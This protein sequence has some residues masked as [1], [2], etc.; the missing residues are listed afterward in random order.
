MRLFPLPPRIFMLCV[1]F[2]SAV[3]LSSAMWVEHI[4]KWQPC[5]LCVY[6]RIP[7]VVLG[8][9]AF[10]SMARRLSPLATRW[11]VVAMVFM[12]ATGAMLSIYH[13]GVEEGL[14]SFQACSGSTQ[15]IESITELMKGLDQ[16]FRPSC[17]DVSWR[18]LGIS[19]SG[20][21]AIVSLGLCLLGLDVY[22]RGLTCGKR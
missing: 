5:I 4:L 16:P 10:L 3:A 2:C 1:A 9:I 22:N 20:Y 7:W 17:V 15:D 19:L 14:W 12:C 8:G 13:T 18:L 21:N 11:T 6:E